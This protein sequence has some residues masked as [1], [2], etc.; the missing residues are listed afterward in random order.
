ML[1][2]KSKPT[3]RVVILSRPVGICCVCKRR[4]IET[5]YQTYGRCDICD[6]LAE[7]RHHHAHTI[8]VKV[9]RTMHTEVVRLPHTICTEG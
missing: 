1:Y 3:R 2:F 9:G 8:T 5:R 7:E 4:G 6:S